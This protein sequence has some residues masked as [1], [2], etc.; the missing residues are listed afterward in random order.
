VIDIQVTVADLDDPRID[1]ALP[2]IGWIPSEPRT[3]HTPPGMSIEPDGLQKRFATRTADSDRQA[4]LHIRVAGRF[5]QR[6]SLLCR[7]YLI[8]HPDAAAAYGELKRR[9][10]R[11]V[12]GDIGAFH[13]VKDPAV[14]VVMAAAEAWATATAWTPPTPTHG[15][16]R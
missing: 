11:H 13:E 6:Y 1:A 14:D 9:L 7:D 2:A 5:N 16:K 15:G 8:E 3:D 4:N 12:A 10:A